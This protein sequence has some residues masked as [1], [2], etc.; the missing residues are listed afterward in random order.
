MSVTLLQNT[1]M[2]FDDVLK[3]IKKIKDQSIILIATVL[4]IIDKL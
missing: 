4:N 2:Y 3:D 1:Q